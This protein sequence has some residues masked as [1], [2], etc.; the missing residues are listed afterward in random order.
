MRR[1]LLYTVSICLVLAIGVFAGASHSVSAGSKSYQAEIDAAKEKKKEMEERQ[2]ELE[3]QIEEL[4]Q[5]KEDM[6]AYI[7]NMDKQYMELMYNIGELEI[8]ISD[9]EVALEETKQLLA[10]A[11]AREEEQYDTMK[12]RI[13]YLYENGETD[14]RTNT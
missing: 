5:Q 11:K 2:K 10:E 8:E 1:K 12:K 4:K 13:K 9:L 7:E 14:F 3:K 6:N